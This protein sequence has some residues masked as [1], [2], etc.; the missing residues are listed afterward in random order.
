[1]SC[2]STNFSDPAKPQNNVIPFSQKHTC[3]ARLFVHENKHK[4]LYQFATHYNTFT[5]RHKFPGSLYISLELPPT[6]CT[7]PLSQHFALSEKK[8][9]MLPRGRGRWAVSQKYIMI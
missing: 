5:G 9:I 7:P 8:V 4:F 2:T 6:A 1:M 3:I